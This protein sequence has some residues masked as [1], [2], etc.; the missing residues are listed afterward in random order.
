MK[1]RTPQPLL[2]PL[3]YTEIVTEPRRKVADPAGFEPATTSLT[4]SWTTT[5][6]LGYQK[7]RVGAASKIRTHDPLLTRQSLYQL[8]YSGIGLPY[9]I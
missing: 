8:S 6:L 2:Y 3:S 7:K 1:L 4:V 5:V 9:R